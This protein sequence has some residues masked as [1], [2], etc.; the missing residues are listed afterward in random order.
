MPSESAEIPRE[1]LLLFDY[2]IFQWRPV[3]YKNRMM[4]S[5]KKFFLSQQIEKLKII[6]LYWRY[7]I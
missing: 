4:T 7:A 2:A 3:A 6:A 1:F 5:A